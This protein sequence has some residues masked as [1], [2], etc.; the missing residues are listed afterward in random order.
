MKNL[1][2]L[3]LIAMVY[4]SLVHASEWE[5]FTSIN[6]YSYSDTNI[7]EEDWFTLR[8]YQPGRVSFLFST[9]EV[10]VK[11]RNWTISAISRYDY[12]S[13]F[14]E[15][16]GELL[17][18]KGNSLNPELGRE[19]DIDLSVNHIRA[20]GLKLTYSWH[21]WRYRRLTARVGLSYLTADRLLDGGI[22]GAATEVTEDRYA[23]DLLVDYDGSQD[24]F[25]EGL[26]SSYRGSG[27][28]LA[29]DLHLMWQIEHFG[30]V[31]LDIDDLMSEIYWSDTLFNEYRANP[32]P[33]EI[34]DGRLITHASVSGK[35]GEKSHRQQLTRRITLTSRYI[36][37]R[38][39]HILAEVRHLGP[40]TIPRFGISF[41]FTPTTHLDLY[42]SNFT[43]AY[44]VAFH[45]RHFFMSITADNNLED[46][47]AV[48]K[49]LT[50]GVKLGFSIPL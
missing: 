2:L 50:A 3:P 34:V 32:R 14:N 44:E 17:Y 22:Y 19:Y 1:P 45:S 41:N 9:A 26:E 35:Q 20:R 31:A 7:H 21:P 48:D 47:V 27:K 42:Q 37:A 39:I 40:V 46:E 38:H 49:L 23:G 4:T 28:G 33:A 8:P 16:T 18:R 30:M 29:L 11:Y 43:G 13:E 15:D 5:V 24:I 36:L 25:F 6:A 12:W 10:G